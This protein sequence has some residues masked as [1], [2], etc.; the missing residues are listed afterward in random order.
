MSLNSLDGR[1]VW[2]FYADTFSRDPRIQ[3]PALYAVAVLK[4]ALPGGVAKF[5]ESKR[6]KA[7]RAYQRRKAAS[8]AEDCRR[9]GI[10][11]PCL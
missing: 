8:I 11:L 7:R 9:A 4:S 5:A 10:P 2:Q 3:W 6:G 1:R